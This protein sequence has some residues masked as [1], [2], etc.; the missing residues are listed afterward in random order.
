MNSPRTVSPKKLGSSTGS[1]LFV[2][3]AFSACSTSTD[4]TTSLWEATLSPILP[5][6]VSGNAAAVAQF[7]RTEASVEIRQGEPGTFYG[8]RINAGT[9]DGEGALQGG[10]AAYPLME[11]DET[12]IASADALLSTVLRSGGSYAARVYLPLSGGGQEILA[13]GNLQESS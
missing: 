9:C 2:F 1:L 4:P 13:C 5:S 11:A 12:G 7:G 8:W 6:V 10:I 3:L